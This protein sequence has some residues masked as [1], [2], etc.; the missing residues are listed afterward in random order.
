MMVKRMC[1]VVEMNKC[2]TV[3]TCIQY[4]VGWLGVY[5]CVLV[6]VCVCEYLYFMG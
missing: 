6:M 2:V 4:R 3:S 1:A 5:K